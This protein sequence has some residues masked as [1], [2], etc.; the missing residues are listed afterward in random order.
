MSNNDFI[1][2][3]EFEELNE[4]IKWIQAVLVRV[5]GRNDKSKETLTKMIDNQSAAYYNPNSGLRE[6][7][8]NC[9]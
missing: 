8:T 7:K 3:A 9:L 1:T 2:R 4:R 6:T 5:Y